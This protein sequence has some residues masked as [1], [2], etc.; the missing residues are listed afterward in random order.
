VETRCVVF[1][2]YGNLLQ[3]LQFIILNTWSTI[4][5]E[6]DNISLDLNNIELRDIL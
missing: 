2:S 1:G 3:T 4:L 6:I 5:K